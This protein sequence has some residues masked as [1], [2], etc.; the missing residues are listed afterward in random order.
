MKTFKKIMKWIFVVAIVYV[1]HVT[2]E[3]FVVTN[4]LAYFNY[5]LPIFV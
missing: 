1:A 5:T 4:L 3:A 2:I